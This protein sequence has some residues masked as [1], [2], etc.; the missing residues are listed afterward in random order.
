MIVDWLQ[1]HVCP[2]NPQN[3]R[4]VVVDPLLARETSS[5]KSASSAT[6][7]VVVNLKFLDETVQLRVGLLVRKLR[8]DDT[9][10]PLEK[11]V[12]CFG[13]PSVANMEKRCRLAFLK[14]IEVPLIALPTMKCRR[15][16]SAGPA[17]CEKRE[18]VV[19]RSE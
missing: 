18:W 3:G 5:R 13:H 2:P 14:Y 12:P 8:G 11:L 10:H 1:V 19:P 15:S 4:A 6:G 17:G 16:R 9:V 7:G